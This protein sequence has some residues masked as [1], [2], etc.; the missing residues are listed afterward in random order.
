MTAIEI[1]Y[2]FIFFLIA[3]YVLQV[4]LSRRHIQH[5]LTHRSEVPSAFADKITLESHQKAADYTD[6][7]N[8]FGLIELSLSTALLAIWTL[9]G[10]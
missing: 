2:S 10:G 4:W 6:T 8:K 3:S 9:G 7:R 5:I 1:T